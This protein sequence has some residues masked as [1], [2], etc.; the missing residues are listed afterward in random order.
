MRPKR[1]RRGTQ[2]KRCAR[3]SG[4]GGEGGTSV[5]A[6][7]LGVLRT[8]N[9]ASATA[10]AT[11]TQ[12]F[13]GKDAAATEVGPCPAPEAAAQ[14]EVSDPIRSARK[15]STERRQRPAV[16]SVAER[17]RARIHA[18]ARGERTSTQY[19]DQGHPDVSWSS[20]SPDRRADARATPSAES[21]AEPDHDFAHRKPVQVIELGFSAG[22]GR[23]MG[24]ARGARWLVDGKGE[25]EQR[26]NFRLWRKIPRRSIQTIKA[27]AGRKKGATRIG[28]E[29]GFADC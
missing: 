7:Q 29:L 11:G 24:S 16:F 28:D 21:R 6:R 17:S 26:I 18:A 5:E 25:F 20:P 27:S 1:M 13:S 15:R 4:T 10:R 9:T 14:V 23:A 8:A 2:R 19:G 3:E 22:P 12:A